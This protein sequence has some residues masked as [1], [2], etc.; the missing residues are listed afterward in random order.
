[1]LISLK[2]AFI[3]KRKAGTRVDE[4]T[5]Q[6]LAILLATRCSDYAQSESQLARNVETPSVQDTLDT[7]VEKGI[8]Q[9]FEGYTTDG[10]L[11][12]LYGYSDND[13]AQAV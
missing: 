2:M 12:T 5:Q 4:L 8:L 1:M 13:Y 7:I 11:S 9:P 3:A 6:E 10:R